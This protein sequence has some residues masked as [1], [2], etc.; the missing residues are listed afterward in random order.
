MTMGKRKL[1]AKKMLKVVLAVMLIVLVL[2]VL[3]PL[4][5]LFVLPYFVPV[6]INS[7]R[8]PYN[9]VLNGDHVEII[10]YT[11]SEE[12]VVIPERIL[13]RE[14]TMLNLEKGNQGA[15]Y[16]NKNV[17]KVIVPDTVTRIIDTTFAKC[18]N[19][20]EVVLPKG[21]RKIEM[22]TFFGCKS[23][24]KVELPEGLEIIE[25]GA[26]EGC[27]RLQKVK[28]PNSV[29]EIERIAF[30]E[31]ISLES[32]EIPN[33]VQK[34]AGNSFKD[35]PWYEALTEEFEL[36]GDNVLIKYNGNS[37]TI[38]VPQGVS[39]MGEKVFYRNEKVETI[40][41]PESV[42]E[43]GEFAITGNDNL[44]YVL[45]KNDNVILDFNSIDK[46][47]EHILTVVS[48]QGSTGQK[49]VEEYGAKTGLRWM[50]LK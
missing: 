22:W 31:C 29:V 25:S 43:I 27:E 18:D 12:E 38:E 3:F 39:Y 40:I 8:I 24:K 36:V 42:K 45:L 44:T 14:V 7:T 47:D 2:T 30:S 34:I 10:E 46:V 15:F 23:L 50:E 5:Y 13:F 35:T 9:Y 4:F 26:F 28:I 32:I 17:R 48:A 6:R 21:L 16:N 1:N 33:T 20:E 37:E 41:V 19:L 11:G 49:H